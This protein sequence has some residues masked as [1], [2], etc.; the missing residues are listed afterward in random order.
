M[1]AGEYEIVFAFQRRGGS[2]SLSSLDLYV[3]Q[4]LPASISDVSNDFMNRTVARVDVFE[5][6]K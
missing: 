4:G 6:N 1:P 2:S 3:G 5:T